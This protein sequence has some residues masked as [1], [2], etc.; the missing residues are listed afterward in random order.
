MTLA[1]SLAFMYRL[2]E[3]V[4][5]AHAGGTFRERFLRWAAWSRALALGLVAL[6]L[7]S[8]I[9]M[10]GGLLETFLYRGGMNLA[11][12]LTPFLALITAGIVYMVSAVFAIIGFLDL[13]VNK[14]TRGGVV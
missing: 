8:F 11:S 13:K 12:F 6:A 3:M 14:E 7:L 4:A 5:M 1:I 2:L 9:P 10:M